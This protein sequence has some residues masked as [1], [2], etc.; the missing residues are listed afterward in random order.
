MSTTGR[1]K[2]LAL[3]ALLTAGAVGLA[4]WLLL[5]GRGTR[6]SGEGGPSA[7]GADMRRLLRPSPGPAPALDPAA[8]ERAAEA[9][10]LALRTA[11]DQLSTTAALPPF[12]RKA[13]ERNPREYL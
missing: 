1:P 6:P 3:L 2:T 12:D 11:P 4:A 10:A 5:A 9:V 7:S 13:F 8:R